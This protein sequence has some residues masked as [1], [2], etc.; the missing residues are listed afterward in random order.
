MSHGRFVPP[1][2]DKGDANTIGGYHAVHARPAAFEG[3]DGFSYSVEIIADR[4]AGSSHDAELPWGAYILFVRWHRTGEQTPAGHLE[5]D[6]LSR[7]TSEEEVIADVSRLPLSAVK[8]LLDA[9][10]IASTGTSRPRRWW[11]AMRDEGE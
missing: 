6:Y 4:V 5:T 3:P 1:D 10:V 2:H 7:G 8:E 9:C 11:D